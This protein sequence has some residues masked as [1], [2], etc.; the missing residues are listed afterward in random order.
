MVHVSTTMIPNRILAQLQTKETNQ[1]IFHS[2]YQKPIPTFRV[3]KAPIKVFR[4]IDNL[5]TLETAY[6]IIADVGFH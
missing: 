1:T 4:N 6:N 2:K 5:Q 3:K